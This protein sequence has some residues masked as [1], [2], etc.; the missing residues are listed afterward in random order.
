M[1]ALAEVSDFGLVPVT[2]AAGSGLVPGPVLPR[3]SWGAEHHPAA[4]HCGDTTT[5]TGLS[6]LGW[7]QK[8]P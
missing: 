3:A 4:T 8:P 1:A 7:P 6:S 2:S 5:Q